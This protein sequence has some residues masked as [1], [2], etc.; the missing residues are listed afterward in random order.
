MQLRKAAY[1]ISGRTLNLARLKTSSYAL[2]PSL[3]THRLRSGARQNSTSG[4]PAQ[5]SFQRALVKL[6][7]EKGTYPF[8]DETMKNRLVRVDGEKLVLRPRMYFAGHPS[9]ADTD[10]FTLAWKGIKAIRVYQGDSISE[11]DIGAPSGAAWRFYDE[12]KQILEEDER[13]RNNDQL[14]SSS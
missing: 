11:V 2:K 7:A 12:Q 3:L 8:S 6:V 14:S 1:I 13:S 4:G 9:W 5:H 10:E